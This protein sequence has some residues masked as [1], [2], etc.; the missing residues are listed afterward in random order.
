MPQAVSL[1]TQMHCSIFAD[2]LHGRRSIHVNHENMVADLFKLVIN[3]DG[4]NRETCPSLNT[5]N[6]LEKITKLRRSGLH[7]Q[8][9]L[10]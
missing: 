9:L 1:I 8:L 2:V 7:V 4:L 10:G 3:Q 5:N 6:A